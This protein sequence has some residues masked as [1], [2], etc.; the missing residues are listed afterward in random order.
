MGRRVRSSC[1]VSS[2]FSRDAL[3]VETER[4]SYK[5]A[6]AGF[7]HIV[8]ARRSVSRKT[9]GCSSSRCEYTAS[10]RPVVDAPSSTLYDSKKCT[11][12]AH[13]VRPTLA[14]S[15]SDGSRTSGTR[16][17]S[18]SRCA[19]PAPS[20]PPSPEPALAPCAIPSRAAAHASSYPS[21]PLRGEA[22]VP[23]SGNAAFTKAKTAASLPPSD[24]ARNPALP[25][26]ASTSHHTPS[27]TTP[28]PAAAA[29]RLK[30][31]VA[32]S[33]IPRSCA[34]GVTAPASCASVRSP[35]PARRLR[36]SCAAG[37][38]TTMW[39]PY[40]SSEANSSAPPPPSP[41]PSG[42]AGSGG[43]AGSTNSGAP[44]SP[45]NSPARC[46]ASKR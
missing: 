30:A 33:S 38:R 3:R 40:C 36:R 22:P 19:M 1:P 7:V 16:T 10:C 23:C 24:L 5:A 44:H 8:E 28:A 13:D 37:A 29:V 31:T 45:T 17:A 35:S 2:P 18:G 6:K 43:V 46:T 15:S 27:T 21:W 41:P 39:S 11:A 4:Q 25:P 42:V 20:P 32:L 9:R 14:R 12:A 26:S 34:P